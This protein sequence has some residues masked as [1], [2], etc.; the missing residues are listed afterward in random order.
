MGTAVNP[1]CKHPACAQ[2]GFRAKRQRLHDSCDQGQILAWL[3]CRRWCGRTARIAGQPYEMELLLVG[4]SKGL[5]GTCLSRPP[6]SM[7]PGFGVTL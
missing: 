4:S 5:V 6:S 2:S 7:H 1:Q 3:S